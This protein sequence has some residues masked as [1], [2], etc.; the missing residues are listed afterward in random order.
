MTQSSTR[1]SHG[2]HPLG[3]CA[4]AGERQRER[5]CP[6]G[7]SLLPLKA[8]SSHGHE[9]RP[10]AGMLSGLVSFVKALRI[11]SPAPDRNRLRPAGIPTKPDRR[12]GPD[13]TCFRSR[14]RCNGSGSVDRH[15]FPRSAARRRI[16]VLK[17]LPGV[18]GLWRCI[19]SVGIPSLALMSSSYG[20]EA[21]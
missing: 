16:Y 15:G 13:V 12:G 3:L 20:T 21:V 9:K 11:S 2:F 10:N 7:Q 17:L 8:F 4:R 19:Y 5:D 18:P 6:N 1:F 14:C